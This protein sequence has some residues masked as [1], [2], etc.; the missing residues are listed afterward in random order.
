[1]GLTSFIA[2]LEGFATKLVSPATKLVGF[3]IGLIGYATKW[4]GPVI[5]LVGL[6]AGL[7]GFATKLV[8]P[9]T[10]L[11]GPIAKYSFWVIITPPEM[12]SRKLF[13]QKSCTISIAFA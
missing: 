3:V 8:S 9:V 4:V 7:I 12:T 6:V 2:G 10:K 11:V 1:M 5:K 13:R